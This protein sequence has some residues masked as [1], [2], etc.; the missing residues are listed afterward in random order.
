MSIKRS[1]VPDEIWDAM[2][3]EYITAEHTSYRQLE[4]KYGVSLYQIQ[5]RGRSDGWQE[6]RDTFKTQG[7]QKTLDKISDFKAE[8]NAKA[9]KVANKALEKLEKSIDAIKNSDTKSLKNITSALKDLKEIGV[10]R[11]ELDRAEQEARIRKLQK[12][13][14]EEHTDTDITITFEEEGYAD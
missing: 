13:A 1:P 9:F 4:K 11:A 14:E 2:K 12:D 7:M 10:F 3:T 5:K 8:Q 6:L